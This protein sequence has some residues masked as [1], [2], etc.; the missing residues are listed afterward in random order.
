[1][2]L[3]ANLTEAMYPQDRRRAGGPF[4]VKFGLKK[5]FSCAWM[6]VLQAFFEILFHVYR[7]RVQPRYQGTMLFGMIA[8]CRPFLEISHSNS[9]LVSDSVDAAQ[10][11]SAR[12]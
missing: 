12:A 3:I 11:D 9:R 8:F 5:P 10:V 2:C 1:M 7:V 6:M 4:L